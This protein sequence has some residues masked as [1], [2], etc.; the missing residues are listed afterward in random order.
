[1]LCN[2]SRRSCAVKR[3]LSLIVKV[4]DIVRIKDNS[5]SRWNGHPMKRQLVGVVIRSN[6]G[7]CDVLWTNAETLIEIGAGSLANLDIIEESIR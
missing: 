6:S 4:G 7:T 3:E 1:M 5:V 2:V